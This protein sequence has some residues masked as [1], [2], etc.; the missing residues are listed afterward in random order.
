MTR[1]TRLDIL[2]HGL[3]RSGSSYIWTYFYEPVI[4]WERFT[5]LLFMQCVEVGQGW[6]IRECLLLSR[7][8][9]RFSKR[10]SP[11]DSNRSRVPSTSTSAL[12]APP[13]NHKDGRGRYNSTASRRRPWQNVPNH[14][15]DK[16]V[17]CKPRYTRRKIRAKFLEESPLM[18]SV[19]TPP[20]SSYFH[21]ANQHARS[22]TSLM[23]WL[24]KRRWKENLSIKIF[25][26][27]PGKPPWSTVARWWTNN[28]SGDETWLFSEN[29]QHQRATERTFVIRWM[30]LQ[31]NWNHFPLKWLRH[32]RSLRS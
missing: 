11:T 31:R 23:S 3:S 9:A 15:S 8:T 5:C 28:G 10:V 20:F 30:S 26:V 27:L 32:R 12:R 1:L 18:E 17:E 2:S 4:H 25:N 29:D 6:S 16:N 7:Y 19:V 22:S 24:P 14:L 21:L 13:Q